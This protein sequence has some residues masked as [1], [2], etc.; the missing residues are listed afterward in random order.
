MREAGASPGGGRGGGEVVGDVEE[1]RY[2]WTMY[3]GK[4]VGKDAQQKSRA[5][6]A[7]WEDIVVRARRSNLECL[8]LLDDG[9]GLS[10]AQK[11]AKRCGEN[12]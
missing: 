5:G 11:A 9:A 6:S 10:E 12:V 7:M 3:C 8:A 4:C 1:R 2:V